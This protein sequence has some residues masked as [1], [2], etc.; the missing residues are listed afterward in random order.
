MILLL[1]HGAIPSINIFYENWSV[2][3]DRD[4]SVVNDVM[5]KEDLFAVALALALSGGRKPPRKRKT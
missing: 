3:Y 1:T 4:W 5:D 2:V